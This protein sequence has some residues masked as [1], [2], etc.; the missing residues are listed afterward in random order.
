MNFNFVLNTANILM[1]YV[2]SYKTSY[3]NTF[4]T[5][6]IALIRLI[7]PFYFPEISILAMKYLFWLEK[8][9]FRV[10]G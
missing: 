1:N 4:F 5:Q 10:A 9:N 8:P 3:N 2:H 7:L 6:I